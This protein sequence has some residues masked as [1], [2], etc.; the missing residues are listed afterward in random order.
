MSGPVYALNRQARDRRIHDACFP[1]IALGAALCVMICGCGG[2]AKPS[3][4]AAVPAASAAPPQAAPPQAA[5]AATP[6]APAAQRHFRLATPLPKHQRRF[7]GCG[8][9]L[10]QRDGINCA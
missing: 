1:I 7:R 8:D 4:Q 6:A 3:P 9:H 2:D 10:A 5:A